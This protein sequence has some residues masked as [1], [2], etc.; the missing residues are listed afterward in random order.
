MDSFDLIFG[1]VALFF[2]VML[3]KSAFKYNWRD[4]SSRYICL[5]DW[6]AFSCISPCG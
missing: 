1:C 6:V 2:I 5:Y 3:I 4:I